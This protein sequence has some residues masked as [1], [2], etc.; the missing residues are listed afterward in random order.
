MTTTPSDGHEEITFEQQLEDLEAVL[1]ELES[2]A[3]SL[4]DML[5]RY[6]RG[7]QLVAACQRQLAEAELRVTQ[8]AAETAGPDA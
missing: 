3:L 2:G 4:D 1:D 6:E 7:M 5:S 8:I